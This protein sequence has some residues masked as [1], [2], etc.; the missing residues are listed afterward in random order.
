MQKVQLGNTSEKI[1]C[2]GFGTMYFGSKVNQ[3]TSYALL[4]YY[5]DRGGSFLDSANK[6]ASWI[7]GCKGGESELIIGKWIKQKG[8]RTDMFLTSK[9]GFPYGEIPRS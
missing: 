7:P 5:V 4:D 6:Y 3:E 1:S 8:N 9:V 2:I